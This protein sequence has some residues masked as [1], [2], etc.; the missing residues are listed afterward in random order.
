M[1]ADVTHRLIASLAD[2]A[3]RQ[4][5]LRALASHLGA[6]AVFVFAPEPDAGGKLIPAPGFPATLPSGRGWRPL[7]ARA[8]AAG[9]HR[10]DVAYPT[11]DED[12]PAVAYSYPGVTY[13]VIGAQPTVS[14]VLEQLAVTAPLTS[15]IFRAEATALYAR[16][17][18]EIARQAA[19]RATTLTR[20]LDRARLDAER[21]TR[22][23]DEFLAMLGHELRNPLAPIVTAL[24]ML[25]LEGVSSKLQGVLER[26][27]SHVQRLVDDLLDVSRITSGKIELRRERLEAASFIQRALEM[28]R[29]LFEQRRT[30]LIVEVPACGLVVD[31][32]PVRLAQVVANLVTNAAKYSEPGKR[33]SIRAER[34]G[35]NVQISVEDQGIGIEPGLLDSVFETFVQVQQGLDRASGGL[36]LGLA[37]VRNLVELHG[38]HVSAFSEGRL[39]GSKFVVVLPAIEGVAD[40][41]PAPLPPRPARTTSGT[42]VLVVDDNCDAA[43][44]LGEL[45]VD[46]GHAVSVAHSGP[47]ALELIMTFR[48]DAALLD[49]GLPVMDGYE[50]ALALRDQLPSIR[51]IALTGYGAPSDRER[52]RA[53]G[54][55]AHLT[56]PVS[57]STVTTTLDKLLAK[58]SSAASA[59]AQPTRT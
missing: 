34:V 48:P 24:Q 38:G 3:H 29:P 22:V 14:D 18:L 41:A 13:V 5:Q 8:R 30:E 11:A 32:D 2:P 15:A 1:N 43:D 49:I 59:G 16:S 37:I 39:R 36:G 20:A 17:D 31:G 40:A 46:H 57:L 44:L 51:L 55:D 42:R 58:S 7:L 45:L 4:V 10:A 27:V 33:I 9:V 50:L 54:F 26:Q 23:K 52:T 56:K 53:A 28:S 25:R 21:A 6:R 35:P 12:A 47:E 19:E